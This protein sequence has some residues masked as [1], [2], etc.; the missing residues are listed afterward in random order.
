MQ[1]LVRGRP[2]TELFLLANLGLANVKWSPFSWLAA[3][4][5]MNDTIQSTL[6]HLERV[7]ALQDERHIFREGT[8]KPELGPAWYLLKTI[9]IATQIISM[10][11]DH[12]ARFDFIA[13]TSPDLLNSYAR[14]MEGIIEFLLCNPYIFIQD[15]DA[16]MSGTD[17]IDV[18]F[19]D[20]VGDIAIVL[21]EG[22]LT[23][24]PWLLLRLLGTKHKFTNY[25]QF[26]RWLFR[27]YDAKEPGRHELC[28]YMIS[29]PDEATELLTFQHEHKWMHERDTFG[30]RHIGDM[31][32]TKWTKALTDKNAWADML[33]D[34]GW[35]PLIEARSI[36]EFLKLP[37]RA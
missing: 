10:Q 34:S 32:L 29:V 12:Q 19:P 17:F 25:K 20:H 11:G 5:R 16:D 21:L 3:G 18:P 1:N 24:G 35:V 15:L 7:G 4:D 8:T 22:A 27:L 13:Q 14:Q 37:T 31:D 2:E 26:V 6:F 36:R 33:L 30:L 9:L 23:F 28:G